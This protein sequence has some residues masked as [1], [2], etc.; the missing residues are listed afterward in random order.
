MLRQTQEPG[1][2]TA[3]EDSGHP[4]VLVH[5]I[6]LPARMWTP[7]VTR[8]APDFRITACDLPGHGA[9]EHR[10]FT[11]EGAVERIGA[12]V[13]EARAATGRAPV[14]A[15]TSLGGISSLAYASQHNDITGLFAHGSTLR[16]DSSLGLPHRTAAR[17]LRL[18]GEERA[19][20]LNEWVLRSVLPDESFREIMAGGISRHAFGEV[21]D[22]LSRWDT[23]ASATRVTTP[24]ILANGRADPLFRR[25]GHQFLNALRS[26]GTPAR[27]VHVPGPHLLALTEPDMFSR[28]LRRAHAELATMTPATPKAA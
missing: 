19:L 8:L 13:A 18:I 26:A 6:R 14:L 16:T 9:L 22:A 15:G 20:R 10:R 1:L 2:W 27:L 25:Q 21:I 17:A 7:I 24:V 5:G 23:L 4:L 12:A 28:L 3:G 11:V